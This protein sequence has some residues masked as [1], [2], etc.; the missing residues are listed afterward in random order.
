MFSGSPH[1]PLPPV[2]E[3]APEDSVATLEQCESQL[4]GEQTVDASEGE[5]DTRLCLLGYYV[6]FPLGGSSE[7]PEK[8][9][10][11]LARLF[12][13]AAAVGGVGDVERRFIDGC[14]EHVC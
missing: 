13:S 12:V 14:E 10:K 9:G 2:D 3:V 11:R 4:R 5:R 6:A 7:S 8:P 1:P